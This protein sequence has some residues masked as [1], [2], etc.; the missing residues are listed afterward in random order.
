M[1]VRIP[2]FEIFVPTLIDYNSM[3]RESGFDKTFE[4]GRDLLINF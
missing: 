1:Q 3:H 4:I 2:A